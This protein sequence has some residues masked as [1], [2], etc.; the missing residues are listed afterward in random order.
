MAYIWDFTVP[1]KFVLWMFF[2]PVMLEF[3]VL[4]TKKFV[5]E[6][7]KQENFFYMIVQEYLW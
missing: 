5:L 1:L 2:V 3:Q 6:I 4:I 7:F